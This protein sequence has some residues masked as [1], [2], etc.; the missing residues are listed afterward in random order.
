MTLL[1]SLA[2]YILYYLH[3]SCTSHIFTIT[4]LPHSII[5]LGNS[6]N[7]FHYTSLHSAKGNELLN[8]TDT[9]EILI[10][11]DP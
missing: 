11:L 2:S 3:T 4:T 6:K 10:K 8:N 7:H 1:V 5:S 9:E